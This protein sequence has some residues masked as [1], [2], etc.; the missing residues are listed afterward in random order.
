M[1]YTASYDPA[2]RIL[3][4]AV[5]GPPSVELFDAALMM[6]TTAVDY[7][8]NVDVIWDF[9]GTDFSAVKPDQMRALLDVRKRYTGREGG[10]AVFVGDEEIAFGMSRM[11]Q[12]LAEGDISRSMHV[13]RTIAEAERWILGGRSPN[14][15]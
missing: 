6:I 15:P 4:V 3:T 7:P 13:T 8:P 1:P 14:E 2:L 5:A 10:R 9:S 11:F 12:I